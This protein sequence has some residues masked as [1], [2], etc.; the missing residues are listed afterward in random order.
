[1][2]HEE[3]SLSRRES[4]DVYGTQEDAMAEK[5]RVDDTHFREVSDDGRKSYLYEDGGGILSP[6]P[7]CVEITEHYENGTTQAFEVDHGIVAGL[8]YGGKG[9]PK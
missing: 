5:H 8:L 6:F 7:K 1:M 9:D 3:A 4:D 2:S